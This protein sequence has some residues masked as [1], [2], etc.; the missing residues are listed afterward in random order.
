MNIK[1][2]ANLIK[3]EYDARKAAAEARY[4]DALSAH[5]ELYEAEKALRAAVL[6]GGDVPLLT[7]RRNDVIRALGYSIDDFFPR[8]RCERCGDTGYSRG[9]FCDCARRRAAEE[10]VEFS[11]P[12]I[13]F[14]DC[15]LDLFEGNSRV[16]A[17]K[18]FSTAKLFCE[19][20]P[21]KKV[22][23]LLLLGTAG[24]GK[25]FLA[26]CIANDLEER[27]YS[28]TFITAFKFNDICRT[29][30]YSFERNRGDALSALSDTDL[31]VID[32]LGSESIIREIT[33]EYLFTVVSERMSSGRHTIITT[34]LNPFELESRYGE[35]TASR[36]FAS[37]TCLTVITNGKDLRR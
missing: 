30:H 33:K 9:R 25:T 11:I 21:P 24:T 32:D 8:P 16:T 15:N 20:F 5:A 4:L 22:R 10:S 34:N 18:A 27:G 35:R 31:L 28:C 37:D 13:T 2:A 36:L 7:E 26:S 23:N 12:P 14:D 29:Y 6:D 1:S 3:N 19:K 17:E